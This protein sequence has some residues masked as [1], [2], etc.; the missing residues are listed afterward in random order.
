MPPVPAGKPEAEVEESMLGFKGADR[1]N[2]GKSKDPRFKSSGSH[3]DYHHR[4]TGGHMK[5]GG[6]SDKH[7][8]QVAK[9]LGYRV[10][11]ADLDEGGMKRQL[12][13][14]PTSGKA[15]MDTF[16]KKPSGKKDKIEINPEMKEAAPMPTKKQQAGVDRIKNKMKLKR[17]FKNADTEMMVHHPKTGVKVIDKKQW[18]MHKAAGYNQAEEVHLEDYE[19][20]E[21]SRKTLGSYISKAS[22]ARGHRKLPTKKVDNRYTG[23]AK[24]SDKI[25][26]MEKAGMKNEENEDT[27]DVLRGSLEPGG[28]FKHKWF[29]EP[30][31]LDEKSM[32]DIVKGMKRDEDGFKKRY[33]DRWKSVMYATANKIAKEQ[34]E[35]EEK[36]KKLDKVDPDELEGDHDDREDGDIDNNNVI[37]KSDKYLHNRRKKVKKEI[38]QQDEDYGAAQDAIAHAKKDGVNTKKHGLMQ[39]YDD[40]HMKKRGYTHRI[41]NTYHKGKDY[42]G[43]GTALKS[44]GEDAETDEG[45]VGGTIGAAIGATHGAPVT[46]YKIGSTVGDVAAVGAAAYAA[47]KVYKVGKKMVKGGSAVARGA[48]KAGSTGHK[49]FKKVQ[50]KHIKTKKGKELHNSFD[51]ELE[52]LMTEEQHNEMVESMSV[53]VKPHPNKKGTHYVVH[54]VGSAMKKHGG[55]KKGETLSDTHIDDL[56]DSGVKVHHEEAETAADKYA[57]FISS[58]NKQMSPS[59]AKTSISVKS[60]EEETDEGLM[61]V[62]YKVGRNVTKAAGHVGM[63]VAK[64]AVRKGERT[65]NVVQGVKK[66]VKQLAG[67]NRQRVFTKQ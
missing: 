45:Y 59:N 3:I 25:D 15:P 13:R 66:G 34:F 43:R 19:L 57:A 29:D 55:V 18:P 36:K 64:A 9:K 42:T 4:Q 1:V 31:D 6:D 48:K 11:E 40:H 35:L 30:V 22:D 46:G 39:P 7:R 63:G 32:E 12:D 10:E 21:L 58:Q 44:I 49:I 54:K 8:Y 67:N 28:T 23:V 27:N 47:H 50:N 60:G 53:H 37:D 41:G 5:S 61:G 20:D 24:A 51:W 52:V 56:N 62:G 2:G 26:K 16:K 33:G 14:D 38:D 17:Q 65:K